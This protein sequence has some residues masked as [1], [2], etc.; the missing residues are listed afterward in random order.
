MISQSRHALHCDAAHVV[1]AAVQSVDLAFSE[2]ALSPLTEP[3][4][5]TR[6]KPPFASVA[7][8]DAT[9]V[10]GRDMFF[11][12]L[13]RLSANRSLEIPSGFSDIDTLRDAKGVIE[14]SPKIAHNSV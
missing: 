8:A 13:K 2:I 14:F 10:R 7:V 11:A 9:F 5:E 4:I 6:T 3:T 1:K 12:G